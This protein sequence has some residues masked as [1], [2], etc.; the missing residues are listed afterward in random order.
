ME[1]LYSVVVHD[2]SLYGS[3]ACIYVGHCWL[4]QHFA[5]V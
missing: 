2:M 3:C 4:T 5:S 1:L